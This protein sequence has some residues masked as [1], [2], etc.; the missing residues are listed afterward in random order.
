[1]KDGSKAAG[2]SIGMELLQ[3]GICLFFSYLC[4]RNETF[5]PP[6]LCLQADHSF[7]KG[8]LGSLDAER[9]RVY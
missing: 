1:M 8:E 9:K 4:R 3:I 2:S 5:L 7:Y 6:L